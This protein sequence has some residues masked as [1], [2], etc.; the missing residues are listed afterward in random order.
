[1]FGA[2]I[3]SFS[4]VLLVERRTAGRQNNNL[5]QACHQ[6]DV[7]VCPG[8]GAGQ[9]K[10]HFT[11]F[12]NLGMLRE[13]LLHHIMVGRI[14]SEQPEQAPGAGW[15]RG[16]TM[17]FTSPASAGPLHKS[18]ASPSLPC[19][20]LT[21]ASTK[22]GARELNGGPWVLASSARTSREWV[23]QTPA[24]AGVS[25]GGATCTGPGDASLRWHDEFLVAVRTDRIAV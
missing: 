22:P 24:K 14:G 16:M 15:D 1:M 9:K 4:D 17:V 8:P 23:M 10:L 6:G 3:P 12:C 25:C 19:S 18:H 21:R 2:A 20:G 11:R 13:E 7:S 5:R